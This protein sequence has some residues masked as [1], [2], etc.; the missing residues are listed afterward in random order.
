[1][2]GQQL[3][4]TYMTDMVNG[5][6]QGFDNSQT[7]AS[8]PA[9]ESQAQQME[10]TFRQSEVNE[11]VGRAKSEAVERYKRETSVQSHQSQPQYQMNA[12]NNQQYANYN[13]QQPAYNGYNPQNIGYMQNMQNHAPQGFGENDFRKLA[14]EEAQRL[15]NENVQQQQRMMHEAEAQRIASEFYSKVNAG[16][17]KYQDYDQ[18]MSAINLGAIANHVELAN[19]FDN[20]ADI[21][22][23]LASNPT[24]IA[25]LKQLIDI[26][27]Q[28][29]NSTNLAQVQMKKISDALKNNESAASYK[30]P[31]QPL[32][33]L[34]P[35]DSGTGAGNNNGPKSA[36]EWQRIWAKH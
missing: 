25:L 23:E 11:L 34:K 20:T 21:M 7:P 33:Q 29:G 3:E 24:E 22:Y 28:S 18:K 8:A 36:K 19:R 16:K 12:N 17:T 4:G 26:D 32:S 13:N 27:M 2:A 9:N 35:S 30:A 10:R 31:Q 6:S 5:V 15:M 1:M 14:A